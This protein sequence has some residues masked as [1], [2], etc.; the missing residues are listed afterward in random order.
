MT[1]DEIDQKI[2][3]EIQRFDAAMEKWVQVA[4]VSPHLPSGYIQVPEA[5]Q[6]ELSAS[7]VVLHKNISTLLELRQKLDRQ[8]AQSPQS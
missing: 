7:Y 1:F 2:N 6:T 3:A 5:A 8:N 4:S